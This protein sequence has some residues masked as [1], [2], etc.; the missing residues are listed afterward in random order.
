MPVDGVNVD[1]LCV[2]P[3]DMN[4]TLDALTWRCILARH[5]LSKHVL[6]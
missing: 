6:D 2:V 1:P 5:G 3:N 4:D